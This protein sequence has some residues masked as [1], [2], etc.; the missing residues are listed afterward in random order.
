MGGAYVND[1]NLYGKTYK[2]MVQGTPES[3]ADESSLNTTFV[4]TSAGT[5]APISNFI[6]L[7]RIYGSANLSR[8]N[9]LNSIQIGASPAPGASTGTLISAVNEVAQKVLP[10]DYSV[11]LGGMARE[12]S[13]GASMML[14]FGISALLIYLILA[15]L[16]ESFLV[17]FSIMFAVPMGLMGAFFMTRIFGLDNNIY[18]QTGV[19]MLIGLLSKTGILIVEFALQKRHEGMSIKDSALEASR[20]R[21][22]PILMT[23]GTM[24]IGLLPLLTSTGVGAMGN[25]S[26]GVGAGTV[27]GLTE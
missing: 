12:Q 5:L 3:H 7:K 25:I 16:Y 9:L 8:F 17:P 26:L 13:Q 27:T 11:E 10:R 6:S 24:V 23:A 22:R 15:C 21:L 18:L 1:V 4:R 14:I 2:V 20:E 19:V